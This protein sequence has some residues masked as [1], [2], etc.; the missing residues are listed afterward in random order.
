MSELSLFDIQNIVTEYTDLNE[1]DVAFISKLIHENMDQPITIA[2]LEQ[3]GNTHVYAVVVA[4][5]YL[6]S[7]CPGNSDYVVNYKKA[8]LSLRERREQNGASLIDGIRYVKEMGF[9]PQYCVVTSTVI[10]RNMKRESRQFKDLFDK[11][12]ELS[13]SPKAVKE[14]QGKDPRGFAA[15]CFYMANILGVKQHTQK[16]V[17]DMF[18]VTEVTVR[19]RYKSILPDDFDFNQS[20]HENEI[21]VPRVQCRD[22]AN[23]GSKFPIEH[24]RGWLGEKKR[25]SPRY[26][27]D[28]HSFNYTSNLTYKRIC[29]HYIPKNKVCL[30]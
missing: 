1:K 13:D 14:R 30:R 11:A 17:S 28:K 9:I 4:A 18:G 27:C 15:G 2:G 12:I 25:R 22:C 19:N 24:Y 3:P 21:I 10:L 29:Y 16:M 6:Y 5:A 26:K 20:R 23:L 8:A 7:K